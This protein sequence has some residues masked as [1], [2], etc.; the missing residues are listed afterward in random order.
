M[1]RDIRS[2]LYIPFVLDRLLLHASLDTFLVS[3]I[4]AP[5]ALSLVNR[6]LAIV[7]TRVVEIFPHGSFEEALET[8]VK[9]AF[10]NTSIKRKL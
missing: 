9:V 4:L 7:A 10:P 1:T 6:A 5:I 3:T 8:C 2:S